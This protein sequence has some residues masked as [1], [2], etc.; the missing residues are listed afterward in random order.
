MLRTVGDQPSLWEAVLP[1]ELRRLPAELAR[2]D[3][4][5]EDPV[6][7]APF[8]PFFD[9]RIGRPSTPMETYLRLMFLKFRYRLGFESLCREVVVSG[10]VGFDHLA[11]V[12]PDRH[13][14][15]GAASDHADEADYP[16]RLGRS[17]RVERGVAGQGGG[18]ETAALHP[19]PGRHH[20]GAVEHRLSHRRGSAGQGGWSDRGDR[21]AD[22]CG[23]RRHEDAAAGPVP[24]S[25]EPGACDRVEAA[26]EG[27]GRAG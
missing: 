11:T 10:G 17:R 6:F 20:S 19:G 12:L 22:P 21:S 8:T 9:P 27:R 14:S 13:R 1:D 2:L 24:R 18:G 23:G 7:F 15:A 26:V 3:A 16:V 4:L 25:G 5:L